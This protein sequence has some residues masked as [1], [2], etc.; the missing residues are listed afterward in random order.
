M[1][2]A[3]VLKERLKE[4]NTLSPLKI[5]PLKCDLVNS[6]E[7]LLK[8]EAK[9]LAEGFE[10]IMLRDPSAPY[11]FGRA[12]L[13]QGN[14]IKLKRFDDA[15]AL[16]LGFQELMENQN[17]DVKDSFGLAKRGSSKEGKVGKGTLGALEV[18]CLTGPFKGKQFCIGT[19]FDQATRQE[20]WDNR[21]QWVGKTITFKYQTIGSVDAPRF[22]VFKAIRE[23]E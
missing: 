16:I 19:G 23:S 17:E 3:D 10:G 6:Y 1:S 2:G 22:P 21:T 12:T 11:K 4:F 8:T 20:I 18:E 5:L 15:E 13:K 7:A 14:L 9:Y